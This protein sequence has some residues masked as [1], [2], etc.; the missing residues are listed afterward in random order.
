MDDAGLGGVIEMNWT[1][2]VLLKSVTQQVME[3]ISVTILKPVV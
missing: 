2:L 3:G 1:L